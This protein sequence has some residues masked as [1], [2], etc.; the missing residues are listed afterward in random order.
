MNNS[1]GDMTTLAPGLPPHLPSVLT[2]IN[3]WCELLKYSQ[4]TLRSLLR[5]FCFLTKYAGR[6][7]WR[8]FPW[9]ALIS[10]K[11]EEGD[12]VGRRWGK[13]ADDGPPCPAI[14]GSHWPA[15]TCQAEHNQPTND[16]RNLTDAQNLINNR[17]NTPS[18]TFYF[19]FDQLR[20]PVNCPR[21]LKPLI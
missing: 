17:Q 13:V 8:Y 19:V 2:I 12:W 16:E 9:W 21:I 3:Q 11:L 15:I 5:T 4:G 6:E 20:Q 10:V 1:V 18:L 14:T 7:I